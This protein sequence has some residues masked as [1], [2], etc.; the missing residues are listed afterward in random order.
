MMTICGTIRSYGKLLDI[1]VFG[2]AGELESNTD[3][4]KFGCEHGEL[5]KY[6]PGLWFY[7]L[8]WLSSNARRK[9]GYIAP[10]T[11]SNSASSHAKYRSMHAQNL[12]L[13]SKRQPEA[14]G[15]CLNRTFTDHSVL[16]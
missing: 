10:L 12:D 1:Y 5:G 8:M 7:D 4:S 3:E 9:S 16:S 6:R 13:A 11:C 15:S 14:V 2:D